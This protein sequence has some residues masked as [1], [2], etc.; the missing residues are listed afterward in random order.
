MTTLQDSDFSN[1][2]DDIDLDLNFYDAEVNPKIPDGLNVALGGGASHPEHQ[3]GQ[4]VSAHQ[5][6]H[7]AQQ[8]LT[9]TADDMSQGAVIFDFSVPM[10]VQFAIPAG[11]HN[12]STHSMI[13][14]T[15]NSAELHGDAMRYM[16]QLEAQRI[17]MEQYQMKKDEAV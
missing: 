2:F 10:D 3:S 16:Q 6:H 15:P 9:S 12:M 11:A 14:P 5:H 8:N 1:L 17:M 7:L 13:P 4:G